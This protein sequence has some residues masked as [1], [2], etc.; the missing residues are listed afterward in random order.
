MLQ[1]STTPKHLPTCIGSIYN[2]TQMEDLPSE[3]DIHHWR[4]R[5]DNKDIATVRRMLDLPEDAEEPE[6]AKENAEDL[7]DG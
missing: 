4:Y 2:P 1:P 7:E 5:D 3:V 6:D